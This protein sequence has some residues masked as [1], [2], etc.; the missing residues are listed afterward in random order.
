[1]N[2]FKIFIIIALINI[3]YLQA[4]DTQT[5]SEIDSKNVGVMVPKEV[6]PKNFFDSFL[7]GFGLI[8]VSEVGDKTFFLTIL[9]AADHSLIET[10]L[11]T[12]AAMCTLNFISLSIGFLIPFF[13]Y[14]NII[15][16]IGIVIFTIF[17]I[18][19]LIEAFSKDKDENLVHDLDEL[20]KELEKEKRDD[21][22]KN[23]KIDEVV[24][25]L[26]KFSPDSK[27]Y[28]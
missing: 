4:L 11:L 26:Q 3:S 24:K 8:F 21:D 1:M 12:S 22:I 20:E 5:V 28:K 27:K 15:D 2:C 14:R 19:M 10:V 17:G 18:M 23:K 13:L 25:L 6:K 7:S 9:Y 16:W